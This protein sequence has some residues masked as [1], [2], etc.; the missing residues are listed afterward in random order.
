MAG[1][2]GFTDAKITE[3]AIAIAAEMPRIESVDSSGLFLVM[4]NL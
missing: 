4:T 3:P 2:I 1:G